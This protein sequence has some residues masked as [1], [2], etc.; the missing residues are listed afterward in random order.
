ML[1]N[2]NQFFLTGA[3]HFGFGFIVG[4]FVLFVLLSV[5]K[6]NIF[7]QLYIPFL[8]FV[9]GIIA[10]LPYVFSEPKTCELHF[11]MN[12]FFLYS[13]A[14]CHSVIMALLGHL[15]IVALLCGVIYCMIVL[16]Y[17]SLVK[18]VRRYGGLSKRG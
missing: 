7:V 8:P 15:H 18:R 6:N 10:V 14:H 2:E 1:V 17:I 16:H 11:W 5:R 13:W 4:A 12:L 3:G 9:L